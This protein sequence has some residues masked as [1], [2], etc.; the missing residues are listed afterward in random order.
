[1]LNGSSRRR[2]SLG[3]LGALEADVWPP[4]H[5]LDSETNSLAQTISTFGHDYAFSILT[6]ADPAVEAFQRAWNDFVTDFLSWKSTPYFWNPT[7]RDQLVEYRAKFNRLLQIYKT[8]G[9]AAT[10]TVAPVVGD[11][12]QPDSLDKVMV[13]VKWGGVLLAGGLVYKVLSDTGLLR[14]L[15]R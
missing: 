15:R 4:T 5:G 13:A 14:N 1:M 9:P 8:L 12:V 6:T 3:G 10:T 7:R 2:R 11:Q